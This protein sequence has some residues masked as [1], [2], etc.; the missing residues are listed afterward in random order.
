M[1]NTRLLHATIWIL[2]ITLSIYVQAQRIPDFSLFPE[3]TGV[4]ANAYQGASVAIE[5]NYVV[6]GCPSDGVFRSG[7]GVV[8]IYSTSGSLLHVIPNPK[9]RGYGFGSAVAISGSTVAV[10]MKGYFQEGG[11]TAI[12]AIFTFDLASATPKV[13]TG[14]VENPSRLGDERFGEAFDISGKILVA[15]APGR[16][17]G[18]NGNAG[19]VYVF[20]LAVSVST[21]RHTFVETTSGLGHV[22]GGAVAID[23]ERVLVG[24]EGYTSGQTRGIGRVYHYKL[25]DADPSVSVLRLLNPK[26]L[27]AAQGNLFGCSV[28]ISG[29]KVVIGARGTDA[30]RGA[31]YTFDV[32]SLNPTA[33][34]ATFT[35]PS[36]PVSADGGGVG[37]SVSISGTRVIVGASYSVVSSKRQAGR[38]YSISFTGGLLATVNNPTPDTGDQFG[39]A[40]AVSANLSVIGAGF[41]DTLGADAGSAYL[42]SGNGASPSLTLNVPSPLGGHN[43]GRTIVVNG[44]RV[45]IASP[46]YQVNQKAVGRVQ[47]FTL[48]SISSVPINLPNPDPA[49]AS[50]FGKAIAISGD[51]V[52]IGADFSVGGRNEGAVY[53]FNLRVSTAPVR[54]IRN[55]N[56]GVSFSLGDA[57]ALEGNRLVI[58]IPRSVDRAGGALYYNLTS[59][60]GPTATL[61]NAVYTADDN[62]GVHVEIHNGIAYI[63]VPGF[64]SS[65]T[66]VGR[67]YRYDL[68]AANPTQYIGFIDSPASN[69]YKSFG[70]VFD[71][72]NDR[73][74]VLSRFFD[75]G[76]GKQGRILVM[77]LDGANS[78]M[79][80]IDNPAF[81]GFG[82][83][84]D[85]SGDL[86]AVGASSYGFRSDQRGRAYVFNIRGSNPNVGYTILENP[87]P[88][89]QEQ[90]GSGLGLLGSRLVVG[91]YGD[92][93]IAPAQGAAYYYNLLTNVSGK[94]SPLEA[95]IISGTGRLEMGTVSTVRANA[96]PGWMFVG[97]TDGEL[98]NPRLDSVSG[99]DSDYTAFFV[100]G[101]FEVWRRQFF[102]LGELADPVFSGPKANPTND[103]VSNDLKFVY[104]FDPR[105]PLNALDRNRLPS[106]SIE[107]AVDVQNVTLSFEI[108]A[109]ASALVIQPEYLSDQNEWKPIEPDIREVFPIN[110]ATNRRLVRLHFKNLKFPRFIVR[111]SLSGL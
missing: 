68:T 59:S 48:S 40:V 42:Y 77:D 24:A 8:K 85:L 47:I 21:P 105:V 19:T 38:A 37:S 82:D 14:I 101:S 79:A 15:G 31:I 36:N 39:S 25:G 65:V 92:G 44:G 87:T 84:I 103:G 73:I 17:V 98:S 94:A 27:P 64:D 2:L 106:L 60:A 28:G 51:L 63:G 70:A 71:I 97:W 57:L 100:P 56:P 1:R 80:L 54:T 33:V 12:G 62:F 29:T 66:D 52:A 111:V 89:F 107:P 81:G 95:G 30:G 23:G 75:L 11:F 55:L 102:T 22:F 35:D 78:L 20:D 43:F 53:I 109:G 9:D 83:V 69:T 3:G 34:V 61:L 13:P 49:N 76:D 10:G 108:S 104:G 96:A 46:R 18:V 50:N 72:D 90:F 5:G 4:Q 45:A 16:R 32:G 7:A 74:A 99:L 88:G 91:A 58:G 26:T 6:V 86:V 41:D 67:I 93:T 110:L